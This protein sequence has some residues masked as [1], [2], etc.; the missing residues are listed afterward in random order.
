M[1]IIRALLFGVLPLHAVMRSVVVFLVRVFFA[2]PPRKQPLSS[3]CRVLCPRIFPSFSSQLCAS[4][5]ATPRRYCHTSSGAYFH[6]SSRASLFFSL[7]SS[8]LRGRH[9]CPSDSV[10]L[11][12]RR[13]G[14]ES[15]PCGTSLVTTT[16][17]LLFRAAPLVSLRKP[18]KFIRCE[19][20]RA[21]RFVPLKR[22]CCDYL[23]KRN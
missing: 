7:S 17:P 20:H 21:N 10:T 19:M 4:A 6:R 12:K 3:L 22:F 16:S 18:H 15:P 2:V 11:L 23:N 13:W 1:V 9:S 14:G 8:H 5:D